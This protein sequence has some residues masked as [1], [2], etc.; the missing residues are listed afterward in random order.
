[1]PLWTRRRVLWTGAAAAGGLVAAYTWRALDD[2]DARARFQGDGSA[3]V[4]FDPWIRIA[5]DGITTFGIHRAEMGQAIVTTLAMLL[6]EELDADWS[7]VRHAFVE[8]DRDYY[9]FGMVGRGE[10]FG[11]TGDRALARAGTSML[12][13]AMKAMGLSMTISSAST[14]DGWDTLRP[15]A[16][17]AR[18][19]L[20]EAAAAR[21]DVP[22][23]ELTTEAGRVR[24]AATGRAFDY[25]VLAAEAARLSTPRDPPLKAPDAYRII[26]TDVPRL[27]APEKIDG[28]ARFGIDVRLPKQR[29]ATVVQCPAF[30]GTLGS[31]NATRAL[32]LPGVERVLRIAPGALAVVATN[33][34]AAFRGAE[35]LEIEWRDPAGT[36]T[37]TTSLRA[38]LIESLDAPDA[39]VVREP[40][41]EPQPAPAPAPAPEL[42]ST[43]FTPSGASTLEA[44]YTVPYLAHA[45]L[46]PMNATARFENGELEVWAPTQAHTLARSEAARVT[47]LEPERVRVH[48]TLLGGGFGRRTECDYVVQA[49]LVARE[50]PGT[51]LQLVWRRSED[52]Q[53]DAYRPMAAGRLRAR[54]TTNGAGASRVESLECHVAAQSVTASFEARTPTPRRDDPK[55]DK[56]IVVGLSDMP[57]AAP[58]LTVSFRP[59]DSPV[60][61]GFWRSVTH[62]Y[63]CYFLESFL[64]EIAE[65]LR[66]DP[67]ALRRQ[68]LAADAR[69]LRVL[70]ELVRRA[71]WDE[72]L[73]SG[74]GRGVALS[75]SHGSIVAHVATVSL[76]RGGARVLDITSVADCGRVIRPSSLRA[77]IEGAV[78][79]GLW[80]AMRSQVTL[81]RGRVVESNFA[82]YPLLRMQEIPRIDVHVLESDERP[83]GAGEPALPPVAPAICN[84]IHAAGAPRVRSLPITQ[85]GEMTT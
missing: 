33:T 19:V 15:V 70:D 73:P 31:W 1:M 68:W 39:I 60:P 46:E 47:G 8:V 38:A 61:V 40:E 49:A 69:A 5:P 66:M 18:G 45:C 6:A 17:A 48:T 14:I 11:P 82:D 62:S 85:P 78:I 28:R 22:V 55:K 44:V 72:S 23:S 20:L 32:T 12:R 41:P 74:Q 59:F 52:L 53:H 35:A 51:P 7:K 83:G 64:D 56:S 13:A 71:R 84:A 77:Q 36:A 54:I 9:N 27:E 25:G 58:S 3:G 80:A 50:L 29:Y 4:A 34:W 21:L 42:E 26:G 76:E 43:P 16:A 75:R 67:I 57:Y 65:R 63:S 2:G 30:G 81:E 24:H 37:D 79:D 10:P